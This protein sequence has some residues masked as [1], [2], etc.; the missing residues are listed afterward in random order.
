VSAKSN[1]VI[2]N[3]GTVSL[4]EDDA[5]MKSLFSNKAFKAG[6]VISPFFAKETLSTPTYLTLQL[7]DQQHILLGPVHLQY[8]NHSCDPNAFFDTTEMKMVA[9]REIQ[10][11]E[12][13]T[14]FYPS[15]EWKMDRAFDCHCGSPRCLKNIQGAFY[16]TK[17][18][19]NH[20]KLNNFIIHKIQQTSD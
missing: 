10:P 12:E 19:Q 1:K 7:D 17:E 13:I 14:F 6:E 9:L 16:L 3:H 4:V 11:G 8:T 20:Y 18:Q 15:T 2:E 5:G